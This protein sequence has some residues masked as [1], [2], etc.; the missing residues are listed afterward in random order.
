MRE[1]LSSRDA[2]LYLGGQAL[3]LFG[4]SALLLTLGIWIKQL[5]GSSAAAGLVMLAMAAP[6]LLAPLAGALVDRVRRRPLL[7]VVNLLTAVAVLPLLAVHDAGDVW[8]IYAVAVLYGLSYTL[9]GAGQSALLVTLVPVRLLPDANGALQSVREGLRLVA[10]L[11]GAGIF[12][13]FGGAAVAMLDASTFVVAAAA[14]TAMRLREPRPAPRTERPLRS[15]AAGARHVLGTTVLRQMTFA[16]AVALLVI[17]FAETVTFEVV[18]TGLD[19]PPTFV[20]VLLAVQGVGAVLGGVTAGRWAHRLGE[21]RLTGAGMAVFAAGT[22]LLTSSQLTVVVAGMVIFGFGVPWILVG[23]MTLLQR[24]TPAYLQGR[25]YAAVE[26][27]TGTPQTLSIAGGA[28]LVAFVDYRV[29]LAVMA[30]VV[31]GA[32][33]YL[34]TRTR[35]PAISG[36]SPAASPLAPGSP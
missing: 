2:R 32:G 16:V 19:R 18:S 13:A 17:G 4:D 5:T 25:A 24:R 12:A 36:A 21:L 15:I 8:L 23:E 34:L 9:I 20:G 1:V 22:V 31:A 14:L 30:V 6:A 11:A 35:L 27:L 28:A 10:P 3:S 29:L 7:V 26:L 33:V